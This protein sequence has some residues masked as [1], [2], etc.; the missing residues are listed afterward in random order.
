MPGMP[1]SMAT[2]TAAITEMLKTMESVIAVKV[3]FCCKGVW[4]D[5]SKIWKSL[6]LRV[7]GSKFWH[8]FFEK[9]TLTP[10]KPYF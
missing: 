3:F 4:V 8:F 10:L 7:S 6:K 2:K 1:I 9:S 5:Y